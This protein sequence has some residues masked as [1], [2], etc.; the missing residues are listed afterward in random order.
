MLLLGLLAVPAF[1]GTVNL[2][3][4][5]LP[6]GNSYSG[7][8][9][10]PYDIAV[11]GGPNQW[12]MCLSYYEHIE[13]WETWQANVVSIGSLDPVT[14]LQDYEAAYLFK[15]AVA[16]GGADGSINAAAWYLFEGAPPLTPGMQAWLT[17]AQGET[18]TKGEFSDVLLYTAIPGSES[19]AGLGTAQNFL[20]STPEPGT[21]VLLGSGLIGLSGM[22]RRKLRG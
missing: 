8:A 3:F 22:L 4:T 15:M 7:I 5:G 16:D 18:Y 1:A 9:S 19:I 20:G 17:L 11:N 21:L 10:Y 6:T 12:M 2:Q 13:G 14:N